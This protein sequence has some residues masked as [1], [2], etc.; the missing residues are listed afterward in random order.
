MSSCFSVPT[1]LAGL[2]DKLA[3]CDRFVTDIITSPNRSNAL[4]RCSRVCLM[5]R[6]EV[7]VTAWVPVTDLPICHDSRF[8]YDFCSRYF[9]ATLSEIVRSHLNPA[10]LEVVHSSV[11]NFPAVERLALDLFH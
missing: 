6:V 5:Y 9:L 2:S 7:T 11:N 3:F 8:R 4:T 10:L 1:K